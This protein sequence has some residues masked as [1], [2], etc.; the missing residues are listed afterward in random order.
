MS[1]APPGFLGSLLPE[2]VRWVPVRVFWKLNA[3]ACLSSSNGETG[4]SLGLWWPRSAFC[5]PLYST[6]ARLRSLGLRTTAEFHPRL[7]HLSLQLRSFYA[8]DARGNGRCLSLGDLGGLRTLLSRTYVHLYM[9]SDW[10]SPGVRAST[11][12]VRDCRDPVHPSEC[13]FLTSY[14]P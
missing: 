1:K 11:L 9:A 5:N 8:H 4:L 12:F 3:V 2:P 13:Q 10:Q 14:D 6:Q 7:Q